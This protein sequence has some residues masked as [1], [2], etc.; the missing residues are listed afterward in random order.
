MSRHRAG[1]VKYWFAQ[2][3]LRFFC[4]IFFD[5]RVSG[6]DNI[7]AKGPVLLLSNHQ[8][9]LDPILC[10]VA[11]KRQLS[12]VARDTLYKSRFYTWL[13]TGVDIIP[14]KRGQVDISAIKMIIKK[15]KA[16]RGIVIFPEAT[17]TADGRIA[18]I[19]SSFGLLSRRGKAPV[20]PVVIDGA[21]EC[22][23]R[24][25]KFLS[26][27]RIAIS[28]GE[29]ITPEQVEQLG[30]EKFAELLTQRLR[31]MQNELRTKLGRKLY[32]YR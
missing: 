29:L 18:D 22:W 24:H 1:I 25:K 27:S 12:Y 9:F 26:L 13:T 15:L 2:K 17:R 31:K 21:F 23:P 3:I 6:I 4:A 20:V 14:I 10:G 16:G 8:S 11:V 30:D 32:E 5:L 19:T 7:P 28:Y